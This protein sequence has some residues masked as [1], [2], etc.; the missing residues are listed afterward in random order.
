MTAVGAQAGNRL[1]EDL[2]KELDRLRAAGTYKRFNTL[3]TPQGAVVEMTGRGKILVLSSNNYL[4]LAAHPLVV[5]AGR[6]TASATGAASP[7][8]KRR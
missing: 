6:P 4:G 5:E 7:E 8:P 2:N 3:R 1:N